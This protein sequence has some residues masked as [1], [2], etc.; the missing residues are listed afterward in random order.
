[1][2][3]ATGAILSRQLPGYQVAHKAMAGGV[4]AMVAALQEKDRHSF[5]RLPDGSVPARKHAAPE[6]EGESLFRG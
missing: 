3:V 5:V 6:K 4:K 1:L 2:P